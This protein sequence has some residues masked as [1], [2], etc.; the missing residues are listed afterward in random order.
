MF[1][2]NLSPILT[3]TLRN[4]AIAEDGRSNTAEGEERVWLC[5]EYR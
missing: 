4:K 5:S 3:D 2:W 1:L